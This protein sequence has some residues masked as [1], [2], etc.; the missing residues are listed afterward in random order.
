MPLSRSAIEE[1]KA[2]YKKAYGKELSDDDAWEMGHRLLR[3]FRVLTKPVD[4]DVD[5]SK[6]SNRLAFD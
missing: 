2:I 4:D 1:L 6:G 3:V 5:S